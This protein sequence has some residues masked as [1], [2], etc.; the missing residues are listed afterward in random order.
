M[1]NPSQDKSVEEE[2]TVPADTEIEQAQVKATEEATEKADEP[3][4]TT[5]EASE[6]AEPEKPKRRVSWSRVAGTRRGPSP[7]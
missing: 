7:A 6:A 1:S 3:T 4:E 2:I 5:E